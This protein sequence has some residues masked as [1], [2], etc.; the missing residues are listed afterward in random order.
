MVPTIVLNL[1]S[2]SVFGLQP[3]LCNVSWYPYVYLTICSANCSTVFRLNFLLQKLNKSSR[4]LSKRSITM[5]TY[6]PSFPKYSIVG[7]PTEIYCKHFIFGCH[8]NSITDQGVNMQRVIELLKL[9]FI[10]PTFSN[11]YHNKVKI[12][13]RENEKEH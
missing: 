7:I 13:L 5:T 12:S 3:Q 11:C 4:L 8:S 6:S 2:A 1:T 10:G 9:I